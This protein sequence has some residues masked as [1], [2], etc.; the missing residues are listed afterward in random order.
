MADG[1]IDVRCIVHSKGDDMSNLTVIC[2]IA[3][4]V[5][6]IMAVISNNDKQ[7]DWRVTLTFLVICVAFVVCAVLSNKNGM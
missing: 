1:C 7:S 2:L 6:G 5:S 3:V 4:W